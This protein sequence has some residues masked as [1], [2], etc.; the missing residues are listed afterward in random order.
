LH[1]LAADQEPIV[2]LGT[3]RLDFHDLHFV[4]Q[5]D[6][7]KHPKLIHAQFPIRKVILSKRFLVPRF[8]C[9]L[10][11]QLFFDCIENDSLI[12]FPE[13]PNVICGRL[14]EFNLKRRAR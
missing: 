5:Y 14:R 11:P 2:L 9:R 6:I 1:L 3:D 4:A 8:S 10:M 7:E 12:E 13:C